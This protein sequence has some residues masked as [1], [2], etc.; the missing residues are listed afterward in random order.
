M[1][2][3]G[4]LG[5]GHYLPPLAD[6]F[7]VRRPIESESNGTS[8]L[9]ET[10]CRHALGR[11]QVGP[12][13]ID[14]IVFATINGDV[15]FPGSA[16]F[17]QDRLGCDT[18]GALDVRAQCTG[19]LFALSVADQF[20]RCGV[21]R[22]IL[23]VGAELHSVWV[24]PSPAGRRVSALFGDAAG[25]W[26]VG[27]ARQGT[28]LLGCVLHTDGT[29]HD[30][31]WCEY[32]ASRQHPVRITVENLRERRHLPTMDEEEVR[33]F[34]REALLS[35]VREVLH[36]TEIPA[37]AV[38]RFVIAHVFPDV[39]E[40]ACRDLDIPIARVAN[41]AAE[42]GHLGSAALPV[43]VSQ[44]LEAGRLESGALVCLAAAGAGFT[45][46]AALLRL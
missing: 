33:R 43:A 24:D 3:T 12:R 46:G 26:V 35:A 11:A 18:V 20:V 39:V 15:T 6:W 2:S 41:P 5:A 31:F 34:G 36:E 25:A 38:D 27:P 30:R 45:W 37:E 4:V 8:A 23:V 10:A 14:F 40:E 44:D 22:Y 21:Y 7:G 16:C 29:R 28:G 13:D 17:L 1:A 42:Y 9:A 19:F 32:P